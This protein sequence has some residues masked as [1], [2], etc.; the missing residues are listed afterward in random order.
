M[1]TPAQAE[2][3]SAL[4]HI[5]EEIIYIEECLL[6]D[7]TGEARSTLSELKS[8]VAGSGALAENTRRTILDGLENASS[9]AHRA[10]SLVNHRR[11][12]T[13]L[14]RERHGQS[15][16]YNVPGEPLS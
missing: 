11:R 12:I 13:N 10:A 8:F 16:L 14:L 7:F 9:G 4:T 15:P 6:E 1:S 5:L 2:L 3:I